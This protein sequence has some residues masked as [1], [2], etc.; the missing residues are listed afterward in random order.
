[1]FNEYII[2][3][4]TYINSL[5]TYF[6]FFNYS[7]YCGYINKL[8]FLLHFKFMKKKCQPKTFSRIYKYID[9]KYDTILL[10]NKVF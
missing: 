4:F 8:I 1:M 7:K 3:N 9:E 6:L 2:H 10:K 5:K